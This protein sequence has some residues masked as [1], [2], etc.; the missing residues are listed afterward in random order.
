MLFVQVFI[1]SFT[2]QLLAPG[3]GAPVC[4]P[5]ARTGKRA[6]ARA[7]AMR[8]GAGVARRGGGTTRECC[9]GKR[10]AMLRGAW[11]R[12]RASGSGLA[13]PVDPGAPGPA[14]RS[15]N[16]IRSRTYPKTGES[17]KTVALAWLMASVIV[18]SHDTGPLIRSKDGFWLAT[19]TETA[20]KGLKGGRITPGEWERR[21]GLR[22]RF[23]YRCRGP[24]LLVAD[25]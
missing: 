8:L 23:I 11:R 9:A 16:S 22:L 17:L 18:G 20:C 1:A 4:G 13:G 19:R 24:S 7:R 5:G 12:P 15:A 2:L 3:A 21:R 10:L 14:R 6:L 25:E